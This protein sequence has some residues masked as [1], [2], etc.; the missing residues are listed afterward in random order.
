MTFCFNCNS[1]CL[2]IYAPD[3]LT[4]L[5]YALKAGLG[6][7]SSLRNP[8]CNSSLELFISPRSKYS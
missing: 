2:N 1:Y 3:F 8:N 4:K 6:V 7:Q 5:Q